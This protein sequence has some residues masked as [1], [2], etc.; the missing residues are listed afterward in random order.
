MSG[1]FFLGGG[2]GWGIGLGVEMNSLCTY[3][4]RKKEKKMGKENHYLQS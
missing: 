2:G 3:K 1:F 4:L